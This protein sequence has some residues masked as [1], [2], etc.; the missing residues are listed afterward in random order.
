MKSPIL[1]LRSLNKDILRLCP[2]VKGL[3]RDIITIEKRFKNE[4]F[5]FLSVALPALGDAFTKGIAFGEFTCPFGFKRAKGQA[6]PRFLSGVLCEVFEP[7]SGKLKEDADL[8]VIKCLREMLYLFKKTQVS[9]SEEENLHK[10]AVAEFFRCDDEAAK[11]IIPDG[12]EYHIGLVSRLV[13]LGLSS[14]PV[15]DIPYKHGPGAVFEGYKANQKWSALTESVR[16]ADSVLDDCGY[17]DFGVSLT[18]LSER[19]VIGESSN[20]VYSEDRVSG[21]TARLVTVPKNSTSRRT[22]TVEPMLNQFVQQGLNTLLRNEISRCSVLS[23]CLALTDQSKNQQLALEGSLSGMWATID[24]KSASD[25]LSVKLVETVFDGHGLFFDRMMD[26]RST[27]IES[28]VIEGHMLAKFAGMGNALTFP[29][30]S[31]CFA[32]VCIAAILD[33]WGLKPT[34]ARVRR[35]SRQIRVFGDDIIIHTDYAQQCVNW[36]EVVGLKVNVNKSF[37]VGNFRESCGV[38]AYKGVDVTPLYVRTRPDQESEGP[39]SIASL[40]ATSNL[41]W[42]RGLY[43]FATA[44]AEEAEFRLG[45]KLPLVGVSCGGLGLHTRLDS[46]NPT[47]WNHRLHRFETRTFALKPLKRRDRLDGYAALLKFFHVPLLGRDVGHLEKSPIRYK[48]RLVQTWVPTY[49]G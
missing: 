25:L 37:L 41:A 27:Y 40:V 30:Q 34:M 39:D 2:A 28:S 7:L 36:L 21:R 45:T 9:A 13:L 4:D 29:V 24:L 1:L 11:V 26:C 49:V 3:D 6:I 48:L 19:S 47:R 10:K 12:Y 35:A 20:R 31:V 42:L 38:D 16:N 44:L 5:G 14:I 33:Q 43:S 18:E 32:V 23:N 46:M 15:D 22:I 17:D 8:G